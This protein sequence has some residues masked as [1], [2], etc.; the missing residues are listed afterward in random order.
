MTL[1]YSSNGY[2]PTRLGRAR[3]DLEQTL[4]TRPQW[5]EAH[6]DLAWVKYLEGRSDEARGEMAKAIQFDPTHL[7]IGIASAQLLAWS[8]DV[9]AAVMELSRLRKRNPEWSQ[10]RAREVAAAWT[11]DPNLLAAIP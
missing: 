10:A 7:G 11:K 3:A 1:A 8:G 4:E 2:E 5:G 9:N 6:A